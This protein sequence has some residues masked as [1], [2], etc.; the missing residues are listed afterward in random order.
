MNPVAAL[1]LTLG[2][3]RTS[4]I[5]L[6][7]SRSGTAIHWR[8]HPNDHTQKSLTPSIN[9]VIL[10]MV[11]GCYLCLIDHLHQNRHPS[12]ASGR[13]T[14]THER[15]PRSTLARIEMSGL[16]STGS[17]KDPPVRNRL[18]KLWAFSGVPSWVPCSPTPAIC[19]RLST[20]R[21]SEIAFVASS[22]SSTPLATLVPPSYMFVF[23]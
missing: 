16:I 23:F 14:R 22:S 21:N 7:S 20:A 18:I 6:S 8:T 3:L 13:I 9:K 1:G 11:I 4:P 12:C 19:V 17:F 5:Q 15:F 2:N 10:S